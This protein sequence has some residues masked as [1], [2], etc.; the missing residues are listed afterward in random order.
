MKKN[1]S[2]YI[3]LSRIAILLLVMC[4]AVGTTFSWYDRSKRDDEEGHVLKYNLTGNVNANLEDVTV[5]TYLGTNKDG[6]VTYGE[7]AL[8]ASADV[9]V[10]AGELAYFRTV[11]TS[12][13]SPG[14]ALVSLYLSQFS[15]KSSMG[16]KVHI[17]VIGPEKIYNQFTGTASGSSYVVKPMLI[18]DNLVLKSN[19]VVEV[20]WFLEVEVSGSVNIGTPYVVNN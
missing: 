16:N 18:E 15:C 3:L 10:V 9:P 12:A 6:V 19:G 4:L 20:Y 13:N 1:S 14:D 17:G 7:D 2:G 11:I 5:E 8:V